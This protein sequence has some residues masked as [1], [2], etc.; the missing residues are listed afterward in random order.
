MGTRVTEKIKVSPVKPKSSHLNN[1][2][3]LCISGISPL[4]SD[5]KILSSPDKKVKVLGIVR[6]CYSKI[7]KSNST[8]FSAA[9][10]LN[11]LK[12]M[13][14]LWVKSSEIARIIAQGT[15]AR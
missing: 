7:P 8:V 1:L 9:I 5:Y 14:V 2:T 10:Y 15:P 4:K 12:L 6:K 3:C 13:P 11:S